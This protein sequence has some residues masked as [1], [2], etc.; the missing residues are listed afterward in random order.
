MK[1]A[2]TLEGGLLRG[3]DQR[4]SE[5]RSRSEFIEAAVDFFI[6]HLE[7][8][9]KVILSVMLCVVGVL[10]I[11]YIVFTR[12]TDGL[13]QRNRYMTTGFVLWPA[14]SVPVD[15]AIT[16]DARRGLCERRGQRIAET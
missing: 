3:I 7:R 12:P 10:A 5:Y 4:A 2:V 11:G 1:T 16:R 9:A 14:G 8:Q 6:R 13:L 15:L